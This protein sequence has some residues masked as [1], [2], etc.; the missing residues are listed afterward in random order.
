MIRLHGLDHIV[1]RTTNLD[2]TA[3][4]AHLARHGVSAG[5]LASRYG[6]Q[7]NGASMYL[8]DPDGNTIELKGRR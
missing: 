8:C 5:P 4:R 6:A 2:A 7:G 3:I 1:L